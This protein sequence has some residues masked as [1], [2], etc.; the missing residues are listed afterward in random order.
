MSSARQESGLASFPRVPSCR[1][2]RLRAAGS[3][4]AFSRL[5]GTLEGRS[6]NPWNKL[7]GPIRHL[8]TSDMSAL[9]LIM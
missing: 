9:P 5:R 7:G 8:T 4:C 6:G 3:G 1:L 2:R